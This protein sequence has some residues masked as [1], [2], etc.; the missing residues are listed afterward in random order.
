[1]LRFMKPKVVRGGTGFWGL[2]KLEVCR[3]GGGRVAVAAQT[4]HSPLGRVEFNCSALPAAL[5][6]A[7][8]SCL[9]SH[10]RPE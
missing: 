3:H 7:L 4:C 8:S 5:N 1:M 6:L 10:V 2:D 9:P